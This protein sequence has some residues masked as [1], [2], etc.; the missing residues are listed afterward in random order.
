[1]LRFGS[2]DP[3]QRNLH[4]HLDSFVHR[5]LQEKMSL[6]ENQGARAVPTPSH[7]GMCFLA[8]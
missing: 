6:H 1:M 4:Y 2:T 3:L 8:L 5:N 7:S